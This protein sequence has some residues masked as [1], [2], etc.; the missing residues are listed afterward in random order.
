MREEKITIKKLLNDFQKNRNFVK[1]EKEKYNARIIKHYNAIDWNKKRLAKIE[2]ENKMYW[3]DV[4]EKIG[5]EIGCKL[6]KYV[7][8]YG[9]FGMR[10]EY[11]FYLFDNI[12]K[13]FNGKGKTYGGLTV[14]C[15]L[16]DD[17]VKLF[18]DTGKK[19]HKVPQGSIADLNG[20]DNETKVLPNTLEEIIK[21]IE[22]SRDEE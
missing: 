15:D 9:P 12:D 20:F 16:L 19:T 18:Y 2:K 10:A 5:N 21:I 7:D 4:V 1:K 17:Q 3:T 13:D 14:T 6:G 11:S 22:E 8:F